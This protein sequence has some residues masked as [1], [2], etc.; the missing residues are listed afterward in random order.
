MFPTTP[1]LNRDRK[2]GVAMKIVVI[3]KSERSKPACC[4]WLIDYPGDR[5]RKRKSA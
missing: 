3:Q 1:D 5:G 2:P 4:P